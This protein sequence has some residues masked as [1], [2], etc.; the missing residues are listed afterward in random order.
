MKTS[1][2]VLVL[3]ICSVS[4]RAASGTRAVDRY[5]DRALGTHGS[6]A[7]ARAA[8]NE[9]IAGRQAAQAQALPRLD[10]SGTYL[11]ADGGRTIDL[12]IGDLLNPVYAT[13]DQLTGR[14][15]FPRLENVRE[16]LNPDNFYDVKLRLSAPLFNRSIGHAATIQDNRARAAEYGIETARRDITYAVHAAYYRWQQATD[17]VATYNAALTVTAEQQRIAQ[18][19]LAN[20]SGTRLALQRA[21]TEHESLT[22]EHTAALQQQSL[23]AA[24]L[25]SLAGLPLD[26]PIDQDSASGERG[27]V[28]IAGNNTTAY[29]AADAHDR[30]QGMTYGSAALQAAEN[31]AADHWWPTVSAFVDLGSQGFDFA[32]NTNTR[33]V[34]AGLSFEWNLFAGFGNEYRTEQ[35]RAARI[36]LDEEKRSV[37]DALALADYAAV[38][39]YNAAVARA[40]AATKRIETATIYLTDV[41]ARFRTGS[42][43]TIEVIDANSQL[44]RARLAASIARLEASLA[45]ADVERSRPTD[46]SPTPKQ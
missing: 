33:Y 43:I 41:L 24:A 27:L 36:A 35:A 45:L 14:P 19:L 5:V 37:R 1:I 4:V 20:G 29:A 26:T 8:Y 40:K 30:L 11:R 15:Q 31:L 25:N 46:S 38:T 22:D 2:I 10:A 7:A 13:L 23:A 44:T 6:I 3:F 21:M 18:S 32:F 34:M 16:Q 42:A 28:A 9:A 17:A 39:R 12:P